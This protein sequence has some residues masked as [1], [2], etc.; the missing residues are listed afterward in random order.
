M[1]AASLSLRM[2]PGVSLTADHEN[3]THSMRPST[4]ARAAPILPDRPAF[5]PRGRICKSD[6]LLFHRADQGTEDALDDEL[7]GGDE[8]G[9]IGIFRA[10]EWAAF[11]HEVALEGCF[12]V[13]ERGDNVAVA[14]LR[15]LHDHNIAVEDAGTGHGIPTNLQRKGPRI[16]RQTDRLGVNGNAAVGFLF[17]PGWHAGWNHS[18]KRNLQHAGPGSGNTGQNDIPH[19]PGLATDRPLFFQEVQVAADRGRRAE[20]EV[21][22]NFTQRGRTSPCGHTVPDEIQNL[23]LAGSQ[24]DD[25]LNGISGHAGCKLFFR[26]IIFSNKDF[27]PTPCLTE[28]TVSNWTLNNSLTPAPFKFD[29]I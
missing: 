2:V 3:Q 8:I 5:G 20:T 21:I 10:Q 25:Q 17:L 11:L 26:P 19:P 24:H 28:T 14:G 16:A 18:K 12:A 6:K 4:A 29:P 27:L 7:A 15:K 23:L 9:V 22:H 13:D 1:R